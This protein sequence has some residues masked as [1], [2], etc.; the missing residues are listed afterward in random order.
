[1]VNHPPHYGSDTLSGI[2]CIDAIEAASTRD[3]FTGFLK[4]QVLKY[5]W[6]FGRKGRAVEDAKKAAWYLDRLVKHLE[7]K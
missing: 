4:G 6:R 2:E 1:M 5:A 7:K 3:E